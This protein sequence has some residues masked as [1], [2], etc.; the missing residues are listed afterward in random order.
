MNVV[1]QAV[2]TLQLRGGRE[3]ER[4]NGAMEFLVLLQIVEK[5]AVFVKA[6][7]T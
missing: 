2:R 6:I 7:R 1:P 3:R 4:E 5:Y